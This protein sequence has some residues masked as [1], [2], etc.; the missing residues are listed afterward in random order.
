M[1]AYNNGIELQK[2]PAMWR[3]ISCDGPRENFK[4]TVPC[5]AIPMDEPDKAGTTAKVIYFVWTAKQ[6]NS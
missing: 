4:S 5:H 6:H 3:A 2:N 1:W